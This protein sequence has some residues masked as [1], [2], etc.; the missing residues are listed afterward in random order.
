MKKTFHFLLTILIFTQAFTTFAQQDQLYITYPFMPL[1]I[2][3][4]Y[5][6]SREVVSISGV[7]R[8]RPLLTS[9]FGVASTSQEYFSFDMPIANDKMAIG[10]Q[11]YNA[12]QILGTGT[13]GILGNLGLY[14][15]FAYRFSL[16]NDGKLAIGVQLGVT[17]VPV[18]FTIGGGSGN[19]AFNSSFGTGIYYNNDDAYFGA[20]LLNINASD[21]YNSPLFISGGYV[22][23]VDD[24]FKIKTGGVIR[25]QSSNAGGKTVFD[26][27]ATGWINDKFGI[28]VW[29]LNTGSE[30][31]TQSILGSFQVQVK[32]FQFG[33]AYDFSGSG[34][35]NSIS[36]EGF[37]QIMLK[38]ELDAGN[39]KS[40]V[41]RYF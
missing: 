24:D 15:D 17:Q 6:G 9:T 14:G 39:G 13:S 3:P 18:A 7:F 1:S 34:N 21:G 11:A 36:N 35:T 2:N 38:Y 8:R 20:S 41:F 4:A 32:K 30:I 31:S 16:P 29:Y 33:Y 23:T 5:A 27:N 40:S 25:K 28:G 26:L 22:F 10:F 37:H 12:Q 19:T